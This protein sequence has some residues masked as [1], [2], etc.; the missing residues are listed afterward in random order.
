MDFD[1]GLL[2]KYLAG[3]ISSDEMQK[4]VDWG[5]A[6]SENEKILSDVMRLRVTYNSMQY[7]NPDDIEKTLG[8]LNRKIDKAN[9]F[10]LV[11][12]ILQ[13]AAVFL[14]LVSCCYGGYKYFK[15]EKYVSIAVAS[16]QDV[17]KVVLP[18]GT[19]VWLKGGSTL[20]Y[21]ASFSDEYRQVSL[22]G[23]A[24]FEVSKKAGIFFSI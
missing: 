13:Y 14:V 3:N 19:L 9:R 1:Y 12:N 4:M 22:Q 18:D 5:H 15:P 6:S 10:H 20:K 16:T 24:F 17:K 23:E 2:A 21:P 11:R 8:K 7:K